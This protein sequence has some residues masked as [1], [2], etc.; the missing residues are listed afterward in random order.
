MS[1]SPAERAAHREEGIRIE[2]ERCRAIIDSPEGQANPAAAV[3]A[4]TATNLPVSEARQLL[5]L[6]LPSRTH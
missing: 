4:A 3:I 6:T 2:R 5:S 1:L